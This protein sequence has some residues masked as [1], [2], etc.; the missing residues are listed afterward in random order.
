MPAAFLRSLALL[1]TVALALSAASAAA[2]VP[3]NS[4]QIRVTHFVY[5]SGPGKW[6][7]YEVIGFAQPLNA[8]GAGVK[9]KA[10]LMPS[11]SVPVKGV[12]YADVNGLTYTPTNCTTQPARSI[13]IA[14]R[15][16]SALP[17]EMQ[18]VA[19]G[20]ALAGTN[21]EYYRVPWTVDAF[22]NPVMW[23]GA[24]GVPAIQAAVGQIYNYD[25]AE[26]SKQAAHANQYGLYDVSLATLNELNLDLIVDGEVAATQS[27][28]GSLI[29][30]DAAPLKLTLR[31]PDIFTC[32]RIVAGDYSVVARYRFNDT[33]TATINAQFDVT[34]SLNQ[35]IEETQKATTKS[36]SSGW[37]VLG[38]GSRKSKIKRSLE[39][40]MTVDGSA[41]TIE[42]TTI[43][44]NDANDAMIAEFENVFF[45]QLSKANVVTNHLAAAAE[46]AQANNPALA[47]AHTDYAAALTNGSEHLETDAVGA[48]AAL[49]K[50]DYAT[51]LAKGVRASNNNDTRTDNFR[52]T[53]SIDFTQTEMQAWNQARSVTKERETSMPVTLATKQRRAPSLGIYSGNAF[54]YNSLQPI[55]GWEQR[56]GLLVG[57]LPPTGALSVGGVIPGMIIMRIDG[58]PVQNLSDVDA[59]LKYLSPGTQI[60][61]ETLENTGGWMN[62]VT[63]IWGTNKTHTVIVGSYP[64]R[65]EPNE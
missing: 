33:Q 61:V 41:N 3:P 23:Q 8:G 17:T 1:G 10:Y 32:N 29:G 15:V 5:P 30:N 55:Y 56:T 24:I 4:K 22:G 57:G 46:A 52:R 39:T 2:Q 25:Q 59:V 9:P 51:F 47:K 45:P 20:A 28:N 7:T 43:V 54:S 19:V 27:Y 64:V 65:Q 21:A 62:P 18:K 16:T 58:Q 63:P 26:V 13:T 49:A 44:M 37:K 40:T 35:F 36:K 50:K 6:A 38:I 53:V 31:S 34:E 14:V 60:Q 48:A 11:L 12:T 42:N